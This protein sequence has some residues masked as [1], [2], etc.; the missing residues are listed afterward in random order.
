MTG[1]LI[2]IQET[3]VSSAVASVSLIG[4]DTTYDLYQIVGNNLQCNVYV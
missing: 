2:K 3:I 4:I 1:S